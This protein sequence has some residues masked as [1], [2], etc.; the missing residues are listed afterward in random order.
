MLENDI[1]GNDGKVTAPVV[2]L[3]VL[4]VHDGLFNGG[5]VHL[6]RSRY[7]KVVL[8]PYRHANMASASAREANH[9]NLACCGSG[10]VRFSLV[11]LL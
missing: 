3:A 9:F 10:G 6:L 2:H 8:C 11:A 7:Q 4:E 1:E 5:G